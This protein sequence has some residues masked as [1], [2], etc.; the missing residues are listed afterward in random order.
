MAEL[1]VDLIV[2]DKGN[3]VIQKFGMNAQKT[4]Y[5]AAGSAKAYSAAL[6]KA[7]AS[8]SKLSAVSGAADKA[9]NSFFTWG[10][11]AR[12]T[13]TYLAISGVSQ[14][15][16][17]GKS[18]FD[19]TIQID[20]LQRSFTAITGSQ[21]GMRQEMDFLRNTA[22][23][24]GQNMYSLAESYKMLSASTQNTRLE[25]EKTKDLFVAMTEAASVLGL[26]SDRVTLAMNAFSQ[27]ASKGTVQMEELRGQLGDH[28]PGAV[29]IA[30]EALGVTTS[31]LMEM[32]KNGEVLAED[33]LPKMARELHKLYGTAAQAASLESGQAAV[34]QLSQEWTDFK[35][36]I[37]DASA[38]IATIHG[39]TN[40]LKFLNAEAGKNVTIGM[41]GI[42][43]A[44]DDITAIELQVKRAAYLKKEIASIQG[45]VSQVQGNTSMLPG[46]KSDSLKEYS[47]TLQELQ[48][49]LSSLEKVKSYPFLSGDAIGKVDVMSEALGKHAFMMQGVS[50]QSESSMKITQ[51]DIELKNKYIQTAEQALQVDRDAALAGTN[52]PSERLRIQT[53]YQEKL[54]D[55][56][57]KEAKR[58]AA[59]ALKAER[60]E[61]TQLN[62]LIKNYTN[63]AKDAAKGA[64][65]W[66]REAEQSIS[67]ME[68][69]ND[70]YATAGMSELDKLMYEQ[71]VAFREAKEEIDAYQKTVGEVDAKGAA[72]AA[73]YQLASARV[74]EAQKKLSSNPA[75]TSEQDMNKIHALTDA[76][77]DLKK[78]LV[79]QTDIQAKLNALNAD[80]T[81]T[82][83]KLTAAIYGTK[84]AIESQRQAMISGLKDSDDFF[85]N[86]KA[87]SL[88]F[89]YDSQSMGSS[90]A[91]AI[92]G[93]F[94]SATDA[95]ADFVTTG[96]LDFSDFA[97]SIISDLARIAIQQNITGVLASSIGSLF[98]SSDV[99]SY[100][101]NTGQ[102]LGSAKGNVFNSPT[103][104]AYS[105]SIVSRPTVFAFASGA[106][107][108][109]EDGDEAIMPLKR[110][111]NGE[112]GVSGSSSGGLVVNIY[113]PSGTTAKQEQRQ[114]NGVNI[115]DVMFE[116]MENKMWTNVARGGGIGAQTLQ[117]TFGL[118]RA[119]GAY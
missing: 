22:E 51:K 45:K 119:V 61:L 20:S 88:E 52:D 49:E 28:L 40:A 25:G 2:N 110:N 13:L 87:G 48:K 68:R 116:Q 32:M 77:D 11:I 19:V 41:P 7:N 10:N 44:A 37:T 118:N 70:E 5:E 74:D 84:D 29:R 16:A 63:E 102:L 23:G 1:K 66:N 80:G 12:G 111:S 98:G 112:L 101:T 89:A 81:L 21:A 113:A 115:V 54:N 86:F 78:A 9:G 117:Q 24:T 109:G 100:G 56:K 6:D 105:N 69:L 59:A 75:G 90:V 67:G 39:I 42:T 46:V 85:D 55:L 43:S 83:E 50:R 35:L 73:Q 62:A 93:G 33:L 3:I 95:L 92:S 36:N 76:R 72:L 38:I 53:V 14:V 106:G 104:S 26:S 58:G 96:K 91:D 108:M 64:A 103:L 60:A 47:A 82:E 94:Q 18:A 97:N 65:E 34:N 30:A 79:D 107:I 4:F 99:A 27:M 57:E 15:A 17:F 114:E 31:R 71:G 8:T